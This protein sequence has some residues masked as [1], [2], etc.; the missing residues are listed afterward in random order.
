MIPLLMLAAGL[1]AQ[2]EAKRQSVKAQKG[3]LNKEKRAQA[4]YTAEADKQYQ[5]ER[6]AWA[7]GPRLAQDQAAAD[8]QRTTSD[9]TGNQAIALFEGS[10]GGAGSD[11]TANAV[12]NAT[13]RRGAAAAGMAAPGLG[14]HERR[15]LG[16]DVAANIDGV[17]QRAQTSLNL[18]P[19]QMEVASHKG[20]GLNTMGQL[21][22]AYGYGGMSDWAT[23]AGADAATNEAKGKPGG[24]VTVR[25]GT[26]GQPKRMRYEDVYD[27][28]GNQYL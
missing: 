13:G 22:A 8:R 21:M 7:A 23:G 4:G 1:L 26:T 6:D 18:L 3:V 19:G 12:R 14:A 20:E 27:R 10:Q 2:G 15:R 28:N 5:A 25:D 11:A 24:M 16:L 9:Q 17:R